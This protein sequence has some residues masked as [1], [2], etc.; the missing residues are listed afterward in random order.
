MPE[1]TDNNE[2]IYERLLEIEGHKEN[3][4]TLPFKIIG[5]KENGFLAKVKGLYAFISF[6]HMPWKYSSAEPWFAIAPSLKSKVFFCRIHKVDRDHNLV[7]LNGEFPQFKRAGL[8]MGESYTGLI[9]KITGSGLVVDIGSH[10]DWKCGSLTG[11]LHVSRLAENEKLSEFKVGQEITTAFQKRMADGQLVFCSDRDHLDW[12]MGIPL[13][14]VGK[15]MWV[16][17]V[18]ESG[19]KKVE[20]LVRGKYKAKL[21]FDQ[22]EGTSNHK[23]KIKRLKNV[24]GDGGIINCEVT[25][26]D[27]KS[28]LLM[29][30]WSEEAG[31]DS[32]IEN[33]IS[34]NLDNHTKKILSKLNK[35]DKN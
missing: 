2:W 18:R 3:G 10:F 15:K 30:N 34:N 16:R 22:E 13:A 29:V 27:K 23:K 9:I 12:Q 33:S 11:F 14:L 25:G 4:D 24:V 19:N 20:L 5:F 31:K 28:R 32:M 7:L 26:Y 6:H 35:K 1:N 17:V 8:T 21:V